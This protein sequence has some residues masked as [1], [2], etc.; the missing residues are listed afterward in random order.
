MEPPTAALLPSARRARACV[1][2]GAVGFV[3][4]QLGLALAIEYWLPE[5]RDPSYGYKAARLVRRLAAPGPRPTLVLLLGS[6]RTA[7]DVNTRELEAE[8]SQAHGSPVVAFNFGIPGAGPLVELLY[9]KRLLDRGVRPDL[10]LIE[11]LP[12]VLAG[13]EEAVRWSSQFPA[14]RLWLHEVPLAR[15]Y[16]LDDELRESWWR[17]WPIPWYTHRY[18]L[19]STVAPWQLPCICRQDW[20]RFVD[21]HGWMQSPFAEPTPEQRQRAVEAA[22]QSYLIG[23][24]GFHLGGPSCAAL[25]ELLEVCRREHVPAALVFLPEGTEFRSWYSPEGWAEIQ[26]FALELS[27]EYHAPLINARTWMADRCFLDSHH[28]LPGATSAFTERLGREGILPLLRRAKAGANEG[29]S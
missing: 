1:L 7:T 20:F 26:G 13:Q 25:R 12:P 8:L 19:V 17:A 28:L 21:E 11:I 18:A 16:V 23:L 14:Q 24:T 27:R 15:R 10:V 22:H 4:L 9:L 3:A 6:S 5:I 29:G 2:W